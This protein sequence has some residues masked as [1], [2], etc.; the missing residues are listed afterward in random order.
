[1]KKSFLICMSYIVAS[2][3]MS[4]SSSYFKNDFRGYAHLLKVLESHFSMGECLVDLMTYGKLRPSIQ[5]YCSNN[6]LLHSLRRS[7][8]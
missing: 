5:H 4:F 7:M 6:S 8:E 2:I 1:M 3:N